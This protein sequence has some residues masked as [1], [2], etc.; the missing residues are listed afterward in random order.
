MKYI[1]I[2]AVVLSLSA[3]GNTIKGFGQDIVG[4]GDRILTPDEVKTDE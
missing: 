1:M 4:M 2:V 3:C